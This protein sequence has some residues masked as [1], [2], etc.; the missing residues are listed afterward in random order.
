MVDLHWRLLHDGPAGGPWN[1]AV[2]EAMARAVGEG[3][4]PATVRLYTWSAPTISLGYLQRI[5][6][7]VDLEA[8]RR[9][10]IGLVRRITGGRAV[11]HAEEITY[12][13]AV[14]LH[15]RW[16]GLSIPEGFALISRGL[17][18]GLL[19]LGV[20]AC[21][22]EAGMG[23]GA[24]RETDACFLLREVPAILAD[25]RKLVGSAQRRWDRSLLQHGSLL[26]D[27]EPGLHQAVF[28]GWPRTDPAAGV[29]SLR[30]LLG[31]RPPIGDV[32]SALSAGFRELFDAPGIAGELLPVE[33]S[34]A[35]DLARSR[36]GTAAWTYLR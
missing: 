21:M 8:C 32:V 29:T 16:R 23:P 9:R 34:T 2:D 27:F 12:S 10:S 15:G 33:R 18:A 36:Y 25:G 17:A 1:M 26:L 30:D 19:R 5:I 24:G 7:G 31:G 13:V 3:Q 11:L 28:P 4:A 6:S 35:E 14:P 22:S 20:K